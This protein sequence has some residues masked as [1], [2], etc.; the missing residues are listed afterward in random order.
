MADD[1]KNNPDPF[2]EFGGTE[3]ES[4]TGARPREVKVDANVSK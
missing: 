2:E 3:Q 4:F 1:N